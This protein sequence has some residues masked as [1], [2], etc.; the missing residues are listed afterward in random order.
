MLANV[1]GVV[2]YSGN[3]IFHY[4]N[5]LLLLPTLIV[6]LLADL[7]FRF[8]HSSLFWA[9]EV[10]G[11]LLFLIFFFSLPYCYGR[12]ELINIDLVFNYLPEFLKW[13]L[14]KLSDVCVAALAILLMWQGGHSAFEMY[15]FEDVSDMLSWPLWPFAAATV[16]IG[17]WLGLNA[18]L[19]LLGLPLRK[20]FRTEV[21]A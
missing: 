5:L 1:T 7:A 11:L 18:I 9:H 8:F 3:I 13:M 6:V 21:G 19:S 4:I 14:D 10:V 12:R 16:M 20:S 17:L 2:V 15:D